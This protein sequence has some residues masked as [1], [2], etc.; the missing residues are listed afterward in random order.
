MHVRWLQI[1]CVYC[2]EVAHM[3]VTYLSKKFTEDVECNT[4]DDYRATWTAPGLEGGEAGDR[5]EDNFFGGFLRRKGD[6]SGR[7]PIYMVRK[8][9]DV[10]R[11]NQ[12][13]TLDTDRN[14]D[15][16]QFQA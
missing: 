3:F 4:P 9:P 2:H 7:N 13:L 14:P 16:P 11:R 1:F 8:F 12:L 10:R 6:V 5:F 15:S